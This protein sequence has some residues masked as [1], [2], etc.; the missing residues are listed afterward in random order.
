MAPLLPHIT[1]QPTDLDESSFLS[2]ESHSAGIANIRAPCTLDA[3]TDWVPGRGL[4]SSTFQLNF[5][6]L[7]GIGGVFSG[8]VGA[9]QGVSGS[10]RGS[11]GCTLC[12]K[13]PRLSSK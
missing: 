12:R 11:L 5:N 10:N 7:C 8:C 13:R 6:A 3:S 4:H 9:L 1:F 2:V